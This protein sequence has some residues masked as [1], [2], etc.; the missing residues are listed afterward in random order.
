[1]SETEPDDRREQHATSLQIGSLS[2]SVTRSCVRRDLYDLTVGRALDAA[3]RGELERWGAVRGPP[4]LWVIDVPQRHRI[5]IAP[6]IGR[7]VI[8][9]RIERSRDEQSA[10][11]TEFLRW[12][13]QAVYPS[14]ERS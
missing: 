1:M 9:P 4:N 11:A 5:T 2:V 13:E 12:F 14:A 6:A 8:L 3:L 7:V 10:H